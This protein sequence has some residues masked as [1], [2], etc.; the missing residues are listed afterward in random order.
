[1]MLRFA[2]EHGTYLLQNVHV[3]TGA[4]GELLDADVLISQG[5]FARIVA[6]RIEVPGAQVIDTAG[7]TLIP[8]LIDAHVHLDYL[9]ARGGF[10]A[11]YRTHKM[12]KPALREVLEAGITTIRCMADPLRFAVKLRAWA[13]HDPR[14][15]PRMLVA[16]PALTAPGGHPAVT[17]ARDNPWLGQQIARSVEFPVQASQVVRELQGD[18]VDHIKIVYQGGVYGADRIPLRQLSEQTM[19]ALVE[20][21]HALGLRVS[22]HTHEE[23]DVETL[24]RAGVDSIEHG[25]LERDIA[26]SETL[27]LWA[28]SGARLVPTLLITSLVSGPDGELYSEQ[29]R[30][31]LAR[32]YA[33]GVRIVVGTDSTVGAMAATSLHD[34]LRYMAEAGMSEGD[35]LRAATGSAAELLGLAERGVIAEGMAADAVLLHSNP[36]ERI[37]NTTDIDL[38]FRDGLLVHESTPWPQPP[39]LAQYALGGPLVVDYT[40]CTETIFQREVLVRY[41]RSNFASEGVRTLTYLEPDTKEVLRTERVVSGTNLVTSEWECEIPGE[42]TVLHAVREG[43][44]ITLSGVFHNQRIVRSFALRGVPWM[45]WLQLDPATFVVSAEDQVRVA[46]IGTVGRGA[47]TCETFELAKKASSGDG[48]IDVEMVIPKWRQFWGVHLRFEAVTGELVRQQ[49]RGKEKQVLQRVR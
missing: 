8:G 30:A 21:A 34:E 16:G 49:I 32:A 10:T 11:W 47:L 7:K 27:K 3:I 44:N 41:D 4:G 31:N 18:G 46:S 5:R 29:A 24:L 22:A 38:V 1:M 19:I 36:L 12:L 13:G 48:F 33:A 26:Q 43:H 14:R 28:T 20:Q 23:G 17:V 35:V 2:R 9:S 39:Q 6:G 15:G 45:Q 42:G 25:V 37:E 40:D